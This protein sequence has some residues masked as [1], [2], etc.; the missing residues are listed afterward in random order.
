MQF[1][2]FPNLAF[3]CDGVVT[4]WKIGTEN[5]DGD[6]AYHQILG[7]NGTNYSHVAETLYTHSRG[8]GIADVLINMS[9]LAGD[10]VGFF[11]PRGPV[12]LDCFGL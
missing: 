1:S 8:E 4:K 11:T 2:I 3:P 5:D 6:E 10:V 9:V 7:P 12:G